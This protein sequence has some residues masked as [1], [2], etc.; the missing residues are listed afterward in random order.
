MI[1]CLPDITKRFAVL[2]TTIFFPQQKKTDSFPTFSLTMALVS[3]TCATL[4]ILDVKSHS[5][6][7]YNKINIK[8]SNDQCLLASVLFGKHVN[9]H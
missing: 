3:F 9:K 7:K 2:S 4:Q 5:Q 8:Q 1:F 6:E